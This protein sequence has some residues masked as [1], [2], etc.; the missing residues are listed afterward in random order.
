M[1][2]LRILAVAGLLVAGPT[3]AGQSVAP[4][5]TVYDS[6]PGPTACI[7]AGDRALMRTYW[8]R[9]LDTLPI[10]PSRPIPA[11]AQD[12]ARRCLKVMVP[13]GL[14]AAT[15]PERDVAAMFYLGRALDD[16]ALATAAWKRAL[17]A[18]KIR[19]DSTTVVWHLDM[20]YANGHPAHLATA[21]RMAAWLDTLGYVGERPLLPND[22]LWVS[23]HD[24]PNGLAQTLVDTATM[25]AELNLVRQNYEALPVGHR[26]GAEMSPVGAQQEELLLHLLVNPRS[27]SA[28]LALKA[29][30]IEVLGDRQEEGGYGG[31]MMLLGEHY[32]P[33]HP[34]FWFG[35]MPADSV[36][37]RPGRITIVQVVVPRLCTCEYMAST[38]HRLKAKY[39]DSVD[40]VLLAQTAG[41]FNGQIKLAP[42][43]EAALIAK[44]VFEEWKVDV[45]LGVF[46][47]SFV[48]Q[49]DPDRRLFDQVIPALRHIRFG[50]EALVI[51]RRGVLVLTGVV[52]LTPWTERLLDRLLESLLRTPAN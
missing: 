36:L 26:K 9:I 4:G 11:I 1:N 8:N 34:D 13:G 43:D 35:R 46:T 39:G 40:I 28:V 2:R 33:V 7:S 14:S 50:N 24:D 42:R 6:Y 22:S 32:G 38:I 48:P 18:Q 51:D 23:Q 47:T 20:S 31:A 19:D 3:V 44:R 37:P 12:E 45:T 49:P 41:H 16:D 17:K 10:D 15:A 52:S 27:D 30:S 21:R 5:A 25:R 29:K